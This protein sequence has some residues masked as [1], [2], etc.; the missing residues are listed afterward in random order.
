M[1]F[2]F[3]ILDFINVMNYDYHGTWETY[4]GLNAPLYANPQYDLTVDNQLLNV[5]S[6]ITT[7]NIITL[8]SR[9]LINVIVNNH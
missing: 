6:D 1:E 7:S 5:V 9:I 4:T 8:L 3:S 2:L